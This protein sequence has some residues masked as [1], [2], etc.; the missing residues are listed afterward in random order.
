MERVTQKDT[1]S[2]VAK[3]HPLMEPEKV[4]EIWRTAQKHWTHDGEAMVRDI[5]QERDDWDQRIP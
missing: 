5:E 1:N 2:D 3:I 4:K